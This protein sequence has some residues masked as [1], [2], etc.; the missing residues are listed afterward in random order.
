ME[1]RKE[2]LGMRKYLSLLLCL[3]VLVPV[4]AC[5]S[6]TDPDPSGPSNMY[7]YGTWLVKE[8]HGNGDSFDLVFRTDM[9]FQGTAARRS[10]PTIYGTYAINADGSAHGD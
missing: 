5:K 9:T 4:A 1:R 3:A 7:A 10:T 8:V 6:S 2:V